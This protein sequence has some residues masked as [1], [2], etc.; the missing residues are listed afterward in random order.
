MK[1]LKWAAIILVSIVILIFAA[2]KI[3]SKSLPQGKTG[4]DAEALTDKMLK[5]I[6]AEAYE[7]LTYLEW[8]FRDNHHFAWN[9]KNNQVVVKW[10]DFE[11]NLS[12]NDI[13]GTATKNGVE[14]IGETAQE[15][16]QTAWSYFANDSFWL[17][18]PYKVRDP[19]TKRSLVE[20][21]KG[22]ALLIT[23]TS[24]GV[25]PGDSYLWYLNDEGRPIAWEM[26]TSIIPVQGMKITWEG[27]TSHK[28]AWFAPDHQGP[29][30]ISVPL[31]IHR[32]E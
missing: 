2:I 12:P 20:T 6:N 18:A 32:I 14:L 13:S 19:G 15:A 5:A 7:E 16:I 21:E 9:K 27:W 4:P 24:G 8:T 23:Y 25:T 31:I 26:W 10:D 3:F 1:F 11:V 22:P 29:G 28:G 30:P 17:V